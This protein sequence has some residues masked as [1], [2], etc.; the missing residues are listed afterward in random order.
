[1]SFRHLFLIVLAIPLTLY[2][3]YR[4]N[5]DDQPRWQDQQ[6]FAFPNPNTPNAPQRNPFNTNGQTP[7]NYNPMQSPDENAS[8]DSFSFDSSMFGWQGPFSLST[9][10]SQNYGVIF[11]GQFTHSLG[12]RNAGSLILE[13]GGKSYRINASWA[14]LFTQHQ[15]LKLSLERFAQKMDFDFASGSTKNWIAQNAIGATYQYLRPKSW[16]RAFHVNAFLS[17]AQSKNLHRASCN[18]NQ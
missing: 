2:A 15:R 11:K 18:I 14:F 13:G 12:E 16:I 8:S 9:T 7:N 6:R 5:T 1:M 17:N 10:Y 4:P 3:T